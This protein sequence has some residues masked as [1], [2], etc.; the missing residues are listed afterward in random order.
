LFKY[1]V[2][3]A[4]DK[5]VGTVPIA[6]AGQM[7]FFEKRLNEIA[8]E[9]AKYIADPNETPG[10]KLLFVIAFA[11]ELHT[12]FLR[13]HP[14]ANG[15]GHIGRFIVVCFAGHFKFWPKTWDIHGKPAEPYV[16]LL[17]QFRNGDRE[18]LI[19]RILDCF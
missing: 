4:G 3:V 12:E 7:R 15:N 14:Y 11:A 2:Y 17:T 18:P 16:A 13:I 6:V 5:A 1:S 19:A 8:L 9:V 10:K